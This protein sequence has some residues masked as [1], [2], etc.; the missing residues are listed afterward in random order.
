MDQKVKTTRYTASIRLA[1][2]TLGDMIEGRHIF[3]PEVGMQKPNWGWE[4]VQYRKT[5]L[6]DFGNYHLQP[7]YNGV[8]VKVPVA[9]SIRRRTIS[10]WAD[11][12]FH[13]ASIWLINETPYEEDGWKV[14]YI[15]ADTELRLGRRGRIIDGVVVYC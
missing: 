3:N 7:S 10:F 4:R 8:W 1:F 9:H 14:E 2:K 11:A 12:N 15:E 13:L 6:I 5:T